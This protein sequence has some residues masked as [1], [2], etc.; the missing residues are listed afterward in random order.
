MS[1]VKVGIARRRLLGLGF[2]MGAGA[3]FAACAP[4]P[5]PTPVPPPKPAAPA[6]TTAPAKPAEPPKPAA[7][8]ATAAPKPAAAA[9]TVA[10]KPT[11]APAPAATAPAPAKP[12]QGTEISINLSSGA[13]EQT[14][15]NEVAPEFEKA[16]GIKLNVLGTPYEN[17]HDKQFLVLSSKSGEYDVLYSAH[18]WADEFMGNGYYKPLRKYIDDRS[19]TEADWDV[20]DYVPAILDGSGS[21]KGTLYALPVS[22]NIR[23]QFYR[24]DL[25]EQAGLKPPVTWDDLLALGKKVTDPAKNVFGAVVPAKQQ[26][27]ISCAYLDILQSFGPWMYDD[28]FKSSVT[29]PEGVEAGEILMQM[30]KYSPPGATG[31]DGGQAAGAFT[32]G[33]LAVATFNWWG[34]GFFGFRNPQAS[35]I[36]DKFSVTVLPKKVKSSSPGGHW[37][38]GVAGDSKKELA[39]W[40]FVKWYTS[41]TEEQ[42][43]VLGKTGGNPN[44]LSTMKAMREKPEFQAFITAYESALASSIALPRVPEYEPLLDSLNKRLSQAAI[45]ELPIRDAL[46]KHEEDVAAIFKKS[47]RF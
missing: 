40:A 1:T 6:P 23:L 46:K 5:T 12:Y 44:R 30:V 4:A 35:K 45:G 9:P 43:R 39:A 33:S 24:T 18:H 36:A 47:G 29:T 17:L 41:K 22:Q 19:L 26:I 28:K 11:V 16:T 31:Y 3:L 34:S 14:M 13:G 20:N 7:P 27:Q 8:T 15:R 10:P 37:I 2:A 21:Y 38:M 25:L 42:K 32:S